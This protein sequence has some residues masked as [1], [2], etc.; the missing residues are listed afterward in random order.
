M[1]TSFRSEL[2]TPDGNEPPLAESNSAVLAVGP[3]GYMVLAQGFEPCLPRPQRGVL[4]T[5][6]KPDVGLRGRI[7]TDDPLLPRQV[8]YTG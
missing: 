1:S 6:T 7:R 4:T 3:R 8:L 5:H 2:A